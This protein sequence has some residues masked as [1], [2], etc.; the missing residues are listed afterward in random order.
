MPGILWRQGP[1]LQLQRDA[2]NLRPMA[3]GANQIGARL[4][5]DADPSDVKPI[6]RALNLVKPT[7]LGRSH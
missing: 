4:A 2:W 1:A 6:S 3:P 7:R 5:T